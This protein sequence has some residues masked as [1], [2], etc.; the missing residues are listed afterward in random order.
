MK[1]RTPNSDVDDAEQLMKPSEVAS[2]DNVSVK[3]VLRWI[4]KRLLPA[5]KLGGQWRISPR[6]HRNYLRERWYG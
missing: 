6:A 5:Y 2:R 1:P 4:E 3:T